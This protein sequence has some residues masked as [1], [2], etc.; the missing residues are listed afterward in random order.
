MDGIALI[1]FLGGLL[2]VTSLCVVL[3]KTARNTA[4]VYALQSLIIVGIFITLATLT[5]STRLYEWAGTAFVTKVLVVPGIILYAA[6][7]CGDAGS[8]L[9]PRIGAGKIIGIIAAEVLVCFVALNSVKLPLAQVF[10]PT[11]AISLSMFFIGLT[12]IVVQR[13]IIKQIFGY[14]LM[15]NGSH[16]TLA[17]LAPNVPGLV[18]TGVATDAF[19][20]VIIMAVMVW[21][22]YKYDHTLNADDLTE[23]KG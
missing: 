15:E 5:G 14:C 21:R 1:N 10:S 16:V 23:L 8:S 2:V 17:L 4:F 6:S 11:L 9:K 22:I 3:T 7:K 13:N 19:I 18:E 12:C 20:A